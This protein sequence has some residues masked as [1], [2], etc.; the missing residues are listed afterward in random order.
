[1]LIDKQMLKKRKT[2]WVQL[3]KIDIFFLL[4]SVINKL[5]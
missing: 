3:E 1:M 5:D 4:L 2:V